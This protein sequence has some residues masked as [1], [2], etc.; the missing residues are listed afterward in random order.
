MNGC[1]ALDRPSAPVQTSKQGGCRPRPA[2]ILPPLLILE[3]LA[4]FRL[5]VAG[6]RSFSDY[7]R[8]AADLD[9][10]LSLRLPAVEIICGGCASGA[11]A[12]AVRYA[13]ERGL[14]L[15][16]FPAQWRLYGAAA[17]PFRNA[18]MAAHGDALVAYWDGCSAGTAS[19]LRCA[20]AR[21]LR[22]VLRRF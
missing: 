5:I 1:A 18:A 2:G 19:M 9:R 11:D 21:G 20:S 3:V 12:L 4:V 7:A 8:L 16:V 6:S 22:V 15:R 14:A 17:G 13:H 10:L